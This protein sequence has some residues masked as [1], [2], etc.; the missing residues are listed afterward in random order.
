MS[1][2]CHEKSG[3]SD[4]SDED[5]TS[6]MLATCAQQ[7]VRVGLVEF[8]ERHDKQTNGRHYTAADRRPTNQV[9]AWAHGKLYGEVARRARHPREY[10]GRVREDATRKLFRWNL[11]LSE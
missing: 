5:A 3:V 6:Y 9:S 1:L 8:G 11:S 7:V 10:V 4:V 2:T